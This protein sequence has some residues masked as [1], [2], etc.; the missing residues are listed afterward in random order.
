MAMAVPKE[1]WQGPTWSDSV[2]PHSMGQVCAWSL[3]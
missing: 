1:W 2:L 3:G